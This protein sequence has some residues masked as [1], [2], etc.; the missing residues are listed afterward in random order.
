M[1]V[2]AIDIETVLDDTM[3]PRRAREPQR[4]VLDSGVTGSIESTSD[5]FAPAPYWKVVAYA[6]A[7][8][9]TDELQLVEVEAR[10]GEE[11]EL[12]DGVIALTKRCPFVITFNGRGFDMPVIAARAMRHRR[13]WPWYFQ[14]RTKRVD[15]PA[16]D[17][18]FSVAA[19][20]DKGLVER[21]K[22]TPGARWDG[23]SK[24]WHFPA[25]ELHRIQEILRS[26]PFDA[27]VSE[28][29]APRPPQAGHLDL[30]DELQDHGAA[31]RAGLD[32]WCATI[33]LPTKPLTGASVA[34]LLAASPE[35]VVAYCAGDAMRTA[36]LG[37]V[38]LQLRGLLAR[39]LAEDAL[40]E[41]RALLQTQ[42]AAARG[43]AA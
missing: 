32:A 27:Q 18:S 40:T 20:Y 15:W 43:D 17:A 9:D 12:L 41:I 34:E 28:L 39:Q 16:G 3:P 10:S 2:A 5:D 6:A 37:V 35:R 4:V 36:A 1:K 25:K 38:L 7:V 33:G 19:P 14:H 30:M 8:V 42:D 13:S 29:A 23:A 31:R 11:A 24:L 26:V 22:A 21:L